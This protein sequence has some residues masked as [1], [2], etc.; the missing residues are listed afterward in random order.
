VEWLYLSALVLSIAGMATIDWRYK[1]AYWYDRRRTVITLSIAITVF[2]VW[3]LFGIALGIFFH[4]GSEFTLP[5]RLLPEFP[6]EELFFLLLLCYCTLVIYQ[7]ATKL[8][9]RT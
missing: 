9:P 2:I 3:D 8:W 1:L 7:G 4:G 5:Y 6:I